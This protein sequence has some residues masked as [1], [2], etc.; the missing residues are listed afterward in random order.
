[1]VKIFMN[2]S[3]HAAFLKANW[4]PDILKGSPVGQL[5]ERNKGSETDFNPVN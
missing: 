3:V 1:M 2:Q 4:M 5:L